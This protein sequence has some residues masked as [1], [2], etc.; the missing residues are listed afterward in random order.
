MYR[1]DASLFI[2]QLVP[3]TRRPVLC[4]DLVIYLRKLSADGSTNNK[5][6]RGMSSR[7]MRLGAIVGDVIIN[8]R[9]V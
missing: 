9:P 8:Y 4:H 1:V 7:T 5:Q 6:A 2:S 3:S